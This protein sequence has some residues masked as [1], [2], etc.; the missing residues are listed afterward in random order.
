MLESE[1]G[2]P[3]ELFRKIIKEQFERLRDADRFWFENTNNGLFSKEEIEQIRKISLWDV[4]VNASDSIPP[5]AMQ[6]NVFVHSGG[7]ISVSWDNGIQD[8]LLL[9]EHDSRV[10]T[11]R[12]I[13]NN[14]C[15]SIKRMRDNGLYPSSVYVF[16][17]AYLHVYN[18]VRLYIFTFQGNS[19]IFNK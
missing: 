8:R 18:I 6:R 1:G 16:L 14:N 12:H 19:F 4:I 2:R 13:D 10:Y 5:E 15:E 11:S 17:L 3:G 9:Y 7:T